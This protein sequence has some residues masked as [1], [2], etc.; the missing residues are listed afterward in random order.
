MARRQDWKYSPPGYN[1]GL[2]PVTRLDFLDERR[3]S[4]S[5]KQVGEAESYEKQ[6]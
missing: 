3:C 6:Q 4:S 1:I 2:L 5:G